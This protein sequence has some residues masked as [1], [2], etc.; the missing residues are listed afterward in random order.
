VIDVSDILGDGKF[1]AV[2]QAHYANADAELVEGGQPCS[3]RPGDR[4]CHG[5]GHGRR[6]H[7]ERDRDDAITTSAARAATADRQLADSVRPS[8][9]GGAA[10]AAPP[11][12][13]ATILCDG[14]RPP[15]VVVR[16]SRSRA[17]ARQVAATVAGVGRDSYRLWYR[18]PGDALVDDLAGARVHDLRA[19]PGDGRRPRPRIDGPLTRGLVQ[20]LEDYQR[21]WS[22]GASALPDGGDPPRSAP[23]RRAL[24]PR[25]GRSWG[26][27]RARQCARGAG[28]ARRA[29]CRP[30]DPPRPRPP[31]TTTPLR[32]AMARARAVGLARCP[33]RDLDELGGGHA[34]PV[35]VRRYFM[36]TVAA[37]SSSR[38]RE[39]RRAVRLPTIASAVGRDQPGE[40]PPLGRR[41]IR[42]RRLGPPDRQVPPFAAHPRPEHLPLRR[43]E[44]TAAP[45][46]LP[47][48]VQTDAVPGL[49]LRAVRPRRA[50]PTGGVEASLMPYAL[51]A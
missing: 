51:T 6:D 16:P 43:P 27:R 19:P 34:R 13:R 39:H 44:R 11:P 25:E 33:P 32:G 17:T 29:C 8:P 47:K 35:G 5:R 26:S 42:H 12:H 49:G 14:A 3:C 21:V 45:A 41:L 36:P 38:P 9:S 22:T 20:N 4:R 40:R 46:A 37:R 10:R 50:P 18:L 48:C 28:L 1:L 2:S 24:P 15:C 7:D 31:L 23:R 30:R